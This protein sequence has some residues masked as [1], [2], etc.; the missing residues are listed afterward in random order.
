M[1]RLKHVL[2]KLTR[3]DVVLL[4]LAI[5]LMMALPLQNASLTQMIQPQQVYDYRLRMQFDDTPREVSVTTYL[6][7]ATAR[8]QVLLENTEATGLDQ[9]RYHIPSGLVGQWYGDGKAATIDYRAL[10]KT[11]AYRFD[12]DESLSFDVAEPEAWPETLASTDVIQANHPEIAQLW[13]TIKPLDDNALLPALQAI[14][15]YTQNLETLAFKGT[16]DALT[17]LRLGAASCN[18]KSRLF[19]ALARHMGLPARLVGGVILSEGRKRTSH[20][21]LEVNIQQQWVPFDP[22][23]GYFAE[24]P[25]HY[26]ELYVGDQALFKRTADINFDYYFDINAKIIAPSLYEFSGEEAGLARVLSLQAVLKALNMPAQAAAI[27]LC[28]PLCALMVTVLRNLFGLKSFGIFM[29]MLVASACSLIGLYTGL[30]GLSVIVGF[31][32]LCHIALAKIKMLKIPRLAALITIVSAATL[33]LLITVKQLST[34]QVGVLSLFP[35]VIISFLADKMSELAEE[36]LWQELL[37]TLLGTLLIVACCYQV[38]SSATLLGLLVLFPEVFLL[39]LAA[40]IYLGCWTGLRINELLR[41]KTVLALGESVLGI[42]QRNRDFVSR[43]NTKQ[44]LR[45]AVDKLATKRILQKQGIPT[46]QTLACFEDFASIEAL[47]A[48]I[49]DQ[50]QFVVKPNAGSQGNGILVIKDFRAGK[51]LTSGGRSFTVGDIKQHL[52]EIINGNY[53]QHG[54]QDSAYIEALIHQHPRLEKIS[55]GGLCDVRVVIIDGKVISTMLRIPTARSGGKA[56]LH[57]GALGAAIDIDTGVIKRCLFMGQELM[58][59]P[60][61]QQQLVGV[62]I[63]HWQQILAISQQCSRVSG[64]GYLGVDIC[65]DKDRGPVVLEL[66]GRPGLE[67]QN[68]TQQ[69]LLA[70]PVC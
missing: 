28:L 46:P 56:N 29:P 23:N 33:L 65:L 61:N 57:Q 54:M 41:F 27:L 48:A 22:T 50:Q 30:L 12:L 58:A 55:G 44:G 7:K 20:Q 51:W 69:G 35:V 6:P 2:N 63:P 18:G 24:L 14:Y 25:A 32:M 3:I 16:T 60:E 64:L 10:V 19:V 5:A 42:N 11:E 45:T 47:P 26:L 43:K 38:I 8:Q 15:N 4:L 39:I 31:G 66:N 53:A 62:V 34:L 9:Q 49:A 70:S 17:A 36:Q 1:T 21:W 13:Q 40:Q 37:L 68:V 52:I 67:I 59:H